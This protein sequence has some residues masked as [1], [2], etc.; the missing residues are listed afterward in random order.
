VI[1]PDGEPGTYSVVDLKPGV[2]VLAID[3]ADNVYLTEEFHY[4]VG[5]V[6]IEAVS[7]GMDAGEEA[8][9]TAKR[10][11]REELGI[12]AAQWTELGSVDPFTANVVSP[13]QLFAARCLTIGE[14]KLE[15]TEL[16]RSVKLPFQQAA[17]MVM[18]GEITH[19]PSCVLILK[20]ALK[21]HQEFA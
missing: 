15:G 13:T 6:T 18:T 9:K 20:V 4:G 3:D 2:C 8:L 10:E 1:R 21:W 16:I 17:Q 7:G 14:P 12:T 5:R 11:L 19:A